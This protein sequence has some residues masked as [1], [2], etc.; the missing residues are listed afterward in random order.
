MIVEEKFRF[1]RQ[2]AFMSFAVLNVPR[3]QRVVVHI[4]NEKCNYTT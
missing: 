4:K 3:A 2:S 1:A